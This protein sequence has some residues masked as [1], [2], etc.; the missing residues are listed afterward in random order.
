VCWV[1]NLKPLKQPEL[2]VRLAFDFRHR[3]DVEFVMV[4]AQQ[5]HAKA[6]DRLLASMRN[7]QN[8]RYVGSQPQSAVEQLIASAHVLVNT[9]T[10]EGFPNTFIQAWLRKVPVVS[11]SVNP[12]GVFDAERYGICASGSYDRLR[13][14]VEQLI[15]ESS[16]RSRI[17]ERAN[18]FARERFS[19]SNIEQVIRLL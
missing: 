10:I 19:E 6:W 1:A 18:T 7:L 5:M 16:L 17:G 9:S 12:D 15:T 11:L 13:D 4:G 2:F 8:L 3:A 14:A